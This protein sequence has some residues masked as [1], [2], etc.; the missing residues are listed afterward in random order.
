VAEVKLN[1]NLDLF[2]IFDDE[3]WNYYLEYC[4]NHDEEPI[5][6]EELRRES[7]GGPFE[8]DKGRHKHGG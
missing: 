8:T 1:P 6:R 2:N 4:E 3:D 5:D 7:Y